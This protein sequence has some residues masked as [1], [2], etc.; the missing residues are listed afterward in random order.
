MATPDQKDIGYEEDILRDPHSLKNWWYYLDHKSDA[1]Q[2]VRNLIYERALRILPRSYK[3]WL[4]YLL[5]RMHAV[6]E[7]CCTDIAYQK[8]NNCFERSLAHMNKYPRIWKEYLTFLMKQRKLTSTRHVFDRALGSLPI[9]QHLQ[10]IWPLYLAFVKES[11]VPETACRVFRRYLK[12]EKSDQEEFVKYLKKAHKLDQAALVLADIV[13]DE[14]FVST[15]GKSK[16]DLWTE[17]LTLIVKNPAEI[18]SMNVE[19]VIRGGIRRFSHEVG[20]LWTSLADYYIR[21]GHF[22]RARDIYEEGINTVST[23]RDFS[24]IFDA[25]TQFE[26]SMLAAKM[27]AAEQQSQEDSIDDEEDLETEVDLRMFRLEQLMKRQ[28]LL[29]S[30]VLLRQNPHNVKEWQKRVG[31]FCK[32]ELADPAKAIMTFTD[33]V[34]TVDPQ[35]ATGKPHTLWVGFARFY[36]KH[37]DL[38]NARVIFEKSTAI[39]YKSVEDLATLWCEYAEFELRHK[40]PFNA[41]AVLQKACTV[42]KAEVRVYR[43]GGGDRGP[44]QERLYK[45]T[46]L[47]AFAADLEES[48]GTRESTKAIYEQIIDIKVATPALIL[49]YAT[50]MEESKFFE[51]AFRVYEKG[52]ALFKYPHVYPIWVSYLRLF[53]Q[54]FKGT[55]VE[56]ARDLFEQAVQGCPAKQSLFIHLLYAKYEEDYGLLKR[57]MDVY[58][59]ACEACAVEDKQKTFFIYI[60]RCG[61]FFGVTKTREIYERAIKELSDK[62][63]KA[64][65]MRY[66]ALERGLGEIDRARMVYVYGSQFCDP[67]LH[68]DYWKTWHDFEVHHGNEDTFKEML[69]VR[70][71][72]TAQYSQA[73]LMTTIVPTKPAE[74]IAAPDNSMAALEQQAEPEREAPANP[75]SVEITNEEEIDLDMLDQPA[76]VD[77][78]EKKVPL[79]VFGSSVMLTGEA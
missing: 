70:R 26:E 33:A 40:K 52:I 11:N 61:E 4:K 66:A 18:K 46:K 74:K 51:E 16:H 12:I 34:T 15:Q 6:K 21:M 76:E 2:E 3:L 39:N 71:T 50:L 41:R 44:V 25:Y 45:S 36:E 68:S 19:A 69:R 75:P 63:L 59:R 20:N 5:E 73:N 27:E 53:T 38:D 31:L 24:L 9:T 56:R 62:D 22:E 57:A 58:S 8:V 42:P 65:C 37:G 55:K 30:S 79:A 48:L 49:N 64:V 32:G 77:V 60:Y 17:L 29:L 47:W 43:K 28:P 13:N 67:R 78:E 7:L 72:V 54:R 10:W 23:V 35:K 1:A 14:S